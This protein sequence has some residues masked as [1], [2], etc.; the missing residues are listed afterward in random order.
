MATEDW[1][2]KCRLIVSGSSEQTVQLWDGELG[3][4]LA[5][6]RGHQRYRIFRLTASR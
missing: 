1:P 5:V 2:V 4:E 6:L 3:A